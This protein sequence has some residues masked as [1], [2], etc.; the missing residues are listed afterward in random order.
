LVGAPH[1]CD[2]KYILTLDTSV[3]GLLETLTDLILV[4]VA[5]RAVDELVA[6]LESV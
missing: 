6:V 1:L 2:D 5:V 4:G 3:E